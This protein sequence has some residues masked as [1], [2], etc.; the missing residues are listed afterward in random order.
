MRELNIF[1][2]SATLVA[3]VAC[4]PVNRSVE[5]IKT[6]ELQT[7]LLTFDVRFANG[8]ELTPTERQGLEQYLDSIRIGY[9]DRVSVDDPSAA[10]AAGR[11]ALIAAVVARHGLFLEAA[12]PVTPGELLPG[13]ARI[14]VARGRLDV[15]ACPDKL[16]IGRYFLNVCTCLAQRD[17]HDI[18]SLEG[19]HFA[20]FAAGQGPNGTGA[21]ICSKHP[22]KR[23]RAAAALKV[24][25]HHTPRFLTGH[26]LDAAA[27]IVADSAKP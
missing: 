22:V 9:G 2:I 24:P 8:T 3:L 21:K 6:P 25:K 17:G 19:N 1:A 11:R 12:A 15:A 23:I 5:S 14:V 7:A 13:S 4:G 18:S 26:S 10:G 27:D 16:P 20:G